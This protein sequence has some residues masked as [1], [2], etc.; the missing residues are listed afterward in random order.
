MSR[1]FSADVVAT[2]PEPRIALHGDITADADPGLPDAYAAATSG[3]PR[4]VLLDFADVGFMNSTG[5][6]LVVEL[7]A[8]AMQH[9]RSLRATGLSQHY[10]EIFEITRLAEHITVVADPA[11]ETAAA[12]GTA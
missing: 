12:G 10:R 7:L 4:S 8:D 6:A 2:A 11:T 1:P 3:G 5:I 9:G